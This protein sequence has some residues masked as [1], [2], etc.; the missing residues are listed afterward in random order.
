[1]PA[2]TSRRKKPR[3]KRA[4]RKPARKPRARRGVRKGRTAVRSKTARHKPVRRASK[5]TAVRRRRPAARA[6]RRR[7][8]ARIEIHAVAVGLELAA[9]VGAGG[10]N[11][12][13]DVRAVQHRLIELGFNWAPASGT[14]DADT[15]SAIRLFQAVKNGFQRVD[16]PQNDGRVDP[17]KDTHRWL[18]AA[19]APRWLRL[20]AG[21]RAQGFLNAEREA[22]GL[23]HE[24]GTS[25][26]VETLFAAAAHYRDAHLA[27]HPAA[28]QLTTRHASLPR[29]GPTPNHRTHQTGLACD[30]R[31]PR[32]D[33]SGLGVTWNLPGGTEAHPHYDRAA[34]RAMLEALHAQPLFR[35]VLFNDPELIAE[36]LCVT[37]QGHDDHMHFEVAP[38]KREDA[39]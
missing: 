2:R 13:E 16:Y 15:I 21:S 25:W 6:P 17:G 9:S 26:L 12:L 5:Q 23:R 27:V 20:P 18:A 11:R 1:M 8:A 36:G 30:A 28:A 24:Y 29:G 10:E 14:A 22:A 38:P 7:A 33:G 32:N 34:M 4:K 37:A 35:R 39:A 19:N 31:V 3:G